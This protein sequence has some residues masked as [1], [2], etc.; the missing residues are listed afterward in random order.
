MLRVQMGD[1]S[2]P[3]TLTG[4]RRLV[5]LYHWRRGKAMPGV[6]IIANAP[7]PAIDR[8]EDVDWTLFPIL[9][10][11]REMM[12]HEERCTRHMPWLRAS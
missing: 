2:F 9:E 4:P 11:Q 12:A 5:A 3:T 6:W 10:A 1:P 7:E 8:P